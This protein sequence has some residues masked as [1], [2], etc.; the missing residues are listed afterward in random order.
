[1]THVGIPAAEALEKLR[2]GNALFVSGE[3]DCGDVSHEA[4]KHTVDHGQEPYAIVITCSDARVVPNAAFS[5]GIGDLF[6]IR[7]AGNVIDDHQLASIEY[8]C[9]HLGTKLVV[10]LGHDY[11]GAVDAALHDDPNDDPEGFIRYIV[12]DIKQA[13]GSETDPYKASVKNV[14]RSVALINHAFKREKGIPDDVEV[15]G[16]MYHLET[17]EVKFQSVNF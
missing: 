9:E 10:V 1:M 17:G 2:A 4:R 11:C 5:A 12:E 16:G 15:V 7:V 6:V 14:K 3:R 13:I 8:A